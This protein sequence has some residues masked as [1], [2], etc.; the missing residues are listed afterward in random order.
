MIS[1][2]VI[3]KILGVQYMLVGNLCKFILQITL[4]SNTKSECEL[5]LSEIEGV[6]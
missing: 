1:G 4:T 5:R 3:H 6:S 2:K